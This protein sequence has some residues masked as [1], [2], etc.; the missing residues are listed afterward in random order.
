MFDPYPFCACGH[1]TFSSNASTYSLV[2]LATSAN[3]SSVSP[4][5]DAITGVLSR[6]SVNSFSSSF[7]ASTPGLD[8]PTEF[9]TPP[10]ILTIV[11]F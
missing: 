6:I 8:K 4:Y 11:G 9:I 10:S 5:M 3:V 7:F 2:L 1:E